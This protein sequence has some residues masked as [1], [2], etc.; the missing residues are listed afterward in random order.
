MRLA[1]EAEFLVWQT[2]QHVRKRQVKEIVQNFSCFGDHLNAATSSFKTSPT[3]VLS[4]H[5][6]F[7][8]TITIVRKK[9][10]EDA[11]TA[12]STPQFHGTSTTF[13]VRHIRVKVAL[14]PEGSHCGRRRCPTNLKSGAGIKALAIH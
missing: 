14:G 9:L 7:I 4:E 1:A 3:S 12:I 2:T 8:L 5:L 6:V 13:P 11:P 10:D